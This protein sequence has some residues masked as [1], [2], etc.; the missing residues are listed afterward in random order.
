V[1]VQAKAEAAKQ[2]AQRA[3][4]HMRE[5][6]TQAE[7][8]RDQASKEAGSAR[9]EA[10]QLRGQVEAMQ[11]QAADLV[12]ILNNRQVPE[13]ATVQPATKTGASMVSPLK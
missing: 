11:A 12:R 8:G 5:R 3:A 10:A 4:D 9:E 6:T 7:A 2:E 13:D 1:T